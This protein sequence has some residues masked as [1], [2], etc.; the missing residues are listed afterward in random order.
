MYISFIF[1]GARFVLAYLILGELILYT[2][3]EILGVFSLR[4]M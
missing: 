3:I 1:N 2:Y 4:K